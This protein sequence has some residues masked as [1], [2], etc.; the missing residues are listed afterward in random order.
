MAFNSSKIRINIFIIGAC[1]RIIDG[2]F[3]WRILGYLIHAKVNT[4]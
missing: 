4:T 1:A 2:R 3:S